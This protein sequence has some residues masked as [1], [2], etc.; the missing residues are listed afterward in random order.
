MMKNQISVPPIQIPEYGLNHVQSVLG[1]GP[2]NQTDGKR[3][4]FYFKA[5][6]LKANLTREK[7]GTQNSFIPSPEMRGGMFG[8]SPTRKFRGIKTSEYLRKAESQAM[9]K[10]YLPDFLLNLYKSR[11]TKSRE[12]IWKPSARERS[13]L[14]P[15][16]NKKGGKS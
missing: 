9:A 3:I 6:D 15:I 4:K 16:K 11:W 12:E 2:R 5:E 8:S 10:E 14:V 1:L 13:T 7:Y